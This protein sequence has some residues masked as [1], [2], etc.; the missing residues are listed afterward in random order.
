[1]IF[2]FFSSMIIKIQNVSSKISNFFINIFHKV[3]PENT[4]EGESVMSPSWPPMVAKLN[5]GATPT[6]A[7]LRYEI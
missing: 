3:N 4:V 2:N 5:C 7:L 1:M 6:V